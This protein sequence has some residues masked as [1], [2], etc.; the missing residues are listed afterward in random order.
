MHINLFED[1]IG[2]FCLNDLGAISLKGKGQPGTV[3]GSI[4][5]VSDGLV[6][7]GMTLK[8]RVTSSDLCCLT[9]FYL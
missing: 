8:G 7:G 5:Y 2:L 4:E 6:S 1:Q 9:G 3:E